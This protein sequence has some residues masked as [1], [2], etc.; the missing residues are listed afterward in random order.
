[1]VML[2]IFPELATWLPSYLYDTPIS[3]QGESVFQV[4]EGG[5]QVDDPVVLPPMN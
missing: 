2:Y 5:F 3:G 1:M 4:P